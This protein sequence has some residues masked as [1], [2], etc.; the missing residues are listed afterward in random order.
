M[1]E[2]V[3]CYLDKEGRLAREH[4]R[5]FVDRRY[6]ALEIA[7]HYDSIM[8]SVTGKRE[9]GTCIISPPCGH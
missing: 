3:V 1:I 6:Q 5:R 8:S 2:V 7:D 4:S 9:F